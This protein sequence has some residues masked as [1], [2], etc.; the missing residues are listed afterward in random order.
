MAD[1]LTINAASTGFYG[2]FGTY[3][4]YPLTRYSPSYYTTDGTN[5]AGLED[6]WITYLMGATGVLTSGT[7]EFLPSDD[8]T[9]SFVMSG[10]TG[11]TLY[12]AVQDPITGQFSQQLVGTA[13]MP[14]FSYTG[15]YSI[16]SGHY[17]VPPGPFGDFLA[18]LDTVFNGSDV[19]D[20]VD[21][22]YLSGHYDYLSNSITSDQVVTINGNDGEDFLYG[23]LAAKNFIY[24]G[25]GN[26]VID[27][28][29]GTATGAPIINF[30]D[31]GA[32]DDTIYAYARDSDTV[33]VHGGTGNDT[34][35][36]SGGPTSSLFGDGNDDY[37]QGSTG[38][39]RFEG[40]AGND[41][42]LD[43]SPDDDDTAVFSGNWADYTVVDEVVQGGTFRVTD[44]RDGS[45]DG[46]DSV[47]RFIENIRFADG[48]FLTSTRTFVPDVLS[49]P[50]VTATLGHDT[51]SSSSD[52]VTADPT[53]TGT[54]DAN[55]VVNFT[56]NGNPTGWT[57]TADANGVWS[58]RPSGLAGGSYT[59]TASET[60]AGGT[61][62]AS[63]TFTLDGTRPVVA[64]F[65]PVEVTTTNASTVHYILTFSEPVTGVDAGQ[66][67]LTAN[68]L[69]GASITD[70]EPVSGSNGTQYVMTVDTG[71]GDGTVALS[72]DPGAAIQDFAGNGLADGPVSFST[73]TVY[74][75]GRMPTWGAIGD[76]NG[77]G[78]ADLVLPNYFAATVGVYLGAGDGTLGVPVTYNSQ[79]SGPFGSIRAYLADV[80]GDGSPDIIT[81]N[82]SEGTIS[83]LLN[84]GAGGFQPRTAYD[85]GFSTVELA[86]GDIDGNGT[87]DLLVNSGIGVVKLLGNGDGTFQSQQLVTS[88]GG[89][90]ALMDIDGDG[91]PDLLVAN[92]GTLAAFINDGSGQFSTGLSYSLPYP[93]NGVAAA[94]VNGDGKADVVTAGY[95]SHTVSVLLGD[96]NG[97]FG[98]AAVYSTGPGVSPFS[99]EIADMNGDG[100]P[101]VVLSSDSQEI[102]VLI[103]NGD[104]IFAPVQG[105]WVGGFDRVTV[106]DLN[107]DGLPDV[108]AANFFDENVDLLLNTSSF[109]GVTGPTYSIDRT[110]P[111]VTAGL[112]HDTGSS[113]SDGV[114]KD[115]ALSG[116]AGPNA[117]VHFTVDG[118]PVAATATADTNGAWTFTPT[119]LADGSHTVVASE[120]DAAGNVGTASLTFNLDTTA[121]IIVDVSQTQ[122]S[123][124]LATTTM[125][126]HS[127]TGDVVTLYEGANALGSATAGA[128]GKWSISLANL[129]NTVHTFTTTDLAG[130]SA[131]TVIL[132]SSG[133][134]KIAAPATGAIVIGGG[135]ADTLAAGA[136]S[137][138]FVFHNGFGKDTIT[139]FDVQHDSL[140]FGADLPL[141]GSFDAVMA[142][143]S[144]YS[145]KKDGF[146]GAVITYDKGDAITLAGVYAADLTPESFHF[147]QADFWM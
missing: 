68:G 142:H 105:F 35:I 5:L 143:V 134:D 50:Q 61:G 74:G 29:S 19:A 25:G 139:G 84:D 24:G 99:P 6:Q 72:L 126:G 75:T 56:L 137:D 66:F 130:N 141:F 101:D 70:V 62:T 128:D 87:L 96:G 85:T 63:L 78:N 26:D 67:S 7:T 34:I 37:L 95:S 133:A 120:T 27:L 106:G 4:E 64:G 90:I 111:E 132:G 53:L 119:G 146:V 21:A 18:N 116:S 8:G 1:A 55:A 54:G 46:T 108:V 48:T 31:G 52:G 65:D 28:N 131:P 104:G 97:G 113:S 100:H 79:F 40:G 138:F 145:T 82:D 121:P 38:N 81:A 12:V 122:V 11:L 51:G 94:D 71:S 10:Y 47:N 110:A 86:A 43:V 109:G 3:L 60:N 91:R 73:Q 88:T 2:P 127:E 125:S 77:D 36:V 32:D 93:V 89:D 136:G 57:T 112:G 129:S 83:V 144:D 22:S 107:N 15:S 44:L 9:G 80:N 123:K 98:A 45:P 103:N 42:L 49:A 23:S 76:V 17:D 124:K 30:A 117:V 135:G 92:G 41:T 14:A 118:N 59:V 102:G 58:F 20:F 33:T 13:T 69:V 39:D 140:V 115:P 114:T 16:N 147:I